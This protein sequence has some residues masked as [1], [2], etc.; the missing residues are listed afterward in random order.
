MDRHVLLLWSRC[1]SNSAGEETVSRYSQ[2][3]LGHCCISMLWELRCALWCGL[4]ASALTKSSRSLLASCDRLG[5]SAIRWH[6]CSD[7]NGRISVIPRPPVLNGLLGV[8]QTK[9]STSSLH[10]VRYTYLA[11]R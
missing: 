5:G 1:L 11:A 7:L 9:F 6:S 8:I 4:M 2:E 10:F 3:G